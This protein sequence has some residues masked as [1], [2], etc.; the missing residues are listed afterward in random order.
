MRSLSFR[1]RT[2]WTPWRALRALLIASTSLLCACATPNTRQQSEIE[3]GDD[4]GFTITEPVR[5]SSGV[6]GNFEKALRL[7]EEEEYE[8]GI[9]LLEQVTEAAPQATAAHIDLGIA[10]R[11]NGNY[12]SAES[13]LQRALEL[14]PR[15]P[16][17]YNELGIVYR[18]MGRLGEA[19]KSYE[20]ALAISSDFHYARR[21]LAILCDVYLGDLACALEHYEIYA[22]SVPED[23]LVVMWI[24]DLRAREGRK[25]D[26]GSR[27]GEDPIGE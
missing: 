16:V 4:G 24:T 10:H 6:R 1:I 18:K 3:F 20:S 15:H 7:L 21:N 26:I 17:S 22:K 5:V 11:L 2:L 27:T 12:E 8:R 19:R 13:T 23:E 14:N 25:Q 9:E